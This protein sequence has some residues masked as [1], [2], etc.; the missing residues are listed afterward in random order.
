MMGQAFEIV[1]VAPEGF[2][3]TEP[4]GMPDVFV[5]ATMNVQALNSRGWSWFRLWL[6]CRPGVAVAEVQ[7]LLQTAFDEEHRLRLKT[8][9]ADTPQQYIDTFLQEKIMLLPAAT[10]ASGLQKNFRRPL[11][12][13]AALVVLVLLIACTN[14]ANLL[15]AQA[16]TR[17]REMALRVSI[18]ADRWRL[19]RLVLVESALL[20]IA[21]SAVGTLFGWWSAP[22][23]VSMLA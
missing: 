3:A 16:M 17:G 1:G 22:L 19:I 5:P 12:I 10:G 6:R 20:A 9:P 4:G 21:A 14:V 2:T 15:I 7:Q 8:L 13:L 23:I 11:L 18:G